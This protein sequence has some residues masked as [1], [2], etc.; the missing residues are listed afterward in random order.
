MPIPSAD[1]A[2]DTGAD[3]C[4]D[5]L[6]LKGDRIRTVAWNAVRACSDESCC[7]GIEGNTYTT[8]GDLTFDPHGDSVIVA[9]IRNGPIALTR[10]GH[11]PPIIPDRAEFRVEIRFTG[12]P[13][14]RD[15]APG[16]PPYTPTAAEYTAAS[17]HVMGHAEKAY[18]AVK[19]SIADFSLF[20]PSTNPDVVFKGQRLSDLTPMQPQSIIVGMQ[21]AVAVDLAT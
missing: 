12:W 20:P 14:I 13:I 17:R 6:F 2:C 1:C 21:F 10:G 19:R 9:L 3:V 7:G 4:C 15:G 5:T 8:V 11:T 16:Y 18:K